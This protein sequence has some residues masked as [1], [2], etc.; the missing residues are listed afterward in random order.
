MYTLKQT[1]FGFEVTIADRVTHFEATRALAESREALRRCRKPFGVLVDIRFL[2]PLPEDVQEVI[3]ETQRLFRTSGLERSAVVLASAIMTMQFM[4]LAKDS[5]VH[6]QERYV[7]A[8]KHGDWEKI[9]L[10]WILEGVDPDARAK[11]HI[12]S[13]VSAIVGAAEVARIAATQGSRGW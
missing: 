2:R 6:A 1:H 8:S 5:G 3:D 9:A 13:D 12:K 10:A 7:D 4:R 11:R